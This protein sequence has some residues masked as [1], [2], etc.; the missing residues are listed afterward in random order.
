MAFFKCSSIYDVLI[1]FKRG[2]W[3]PDGTLNADSLVSTKVKDIFYLVLF[4]MACIILGIFAFKSNREIVE[5]SSKL[6]DGGINFAV[7]IGFILAFGGR[8]VLF[9][10]R[11]QFWKIVELLEN[12]DLLV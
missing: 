11:I 1:V 3:L 4:E 10:F 6:L 2:F 5:S 7:K 8:L 12:C 9:G